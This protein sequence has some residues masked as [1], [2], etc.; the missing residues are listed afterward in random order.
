MSRGIHRD[1]REE[2]GVALIL[3]LLFIVLLTVIVVEF[4][5]EMQVEAAFASNYGGEFEARLAAR[6]A[7][8]A[9]LGLLAED[10][11]DDDLSGQPPADTLLDNVPWYEGVPFDM[12]NNA[13]MQGSIADEYG[14][15]NLNAVFDYSQS[16]P[17]ER[18]AMVNALRE[19]FALRTEVMP[20][21]APDAIVDAI[22]DWL[23]SGDGEEVRAEGAENEYYMTL[24]NPY[25]CKNGPMD[26]IEELLLI[27]GITPE[28]YHGDPEAEQL[29]LSEYLTV[30]GDWGGRINPNTA[31]EDT[32]AAVIA[33]QTGQGGDLA[34]AQEIYDRA[35]EEPFL[36]VQDLDSYVGGG[37]ASKPRVAAT[38]PAANATEGG[39]N[40]T[41]EATPAQK[42]FTVN[43]NIFR[44]YGDGMLED[45]M[46]RI[47]A[48]VWRTP[49]DP[50]SIE[51][52]S[53]AQSG[54]ET[55]T[56]GGTQGGTEP[57]VLPGEA[58]RILDWKIIQ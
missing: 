53:I 24:E 28:L 34:T 49:R 12:M 29:P 15:L 39:A 22:L 16:P 41:T 46:V 27:R 47:E 21:S 11:A 3:T 57:P 9:A 51:M 5:Y 45:V 10:L 20:E 30:H 7:V 55:G 37:A 25:P 35:R 58:F 48:Y 52:S 1:L 36:D 19:F 26:S 33:G 54:T 43:S 50:S 38:N 18:E 6:S 2:S 31:L 17:V 44:I 4:S 56:E 32:L 40:A 14:K 23:D 42:A 13:V 8:A